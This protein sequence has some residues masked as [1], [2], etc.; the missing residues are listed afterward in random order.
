LRKYL[1]NEYSEDEL[2]ELFGY[3]RENDHGAF[4]EITADLWKSIGEEK[5]MDE[6]SARSLIENAI[7]S[8]KHVNKARYR[9]IPWYKAAAAAVL[10]LVIGGG[11]FHWAFHGK[12]QTA[13]AVKQ[14]AKEY[15]NDVKPGGVKAILKAGQSQVVLNARDTSFVLAGNVVHIKQGDVKIAESEPVQYTL[16]TPKGGEYSLVL[17][18]GTKVT[19]NADSKLVYP[20]VFHGKTRTV[21]L[22]GEGYFTVTTDP[23][24]PFI[25]HTDMQDVRVLGTEFNVQA[26]PDEKKNVTTLI[27]GKVQVSSGG[28]ELRLEDGQQAISNVQGKLTLNPNAD[29]QQAIAWKEG[30]FRFYLTDIREIMRQLSRWYDVE[31][32]Y[33]EG[34]EPR[35]FLAFINRNNNISEVLKMLE[36]TGEIHFQIE[37]R[38]VTV[39]RSAP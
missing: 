20:S 17:S 18:D 31:V 34:V 12:D 2:E 35:E 32:T 8:H 38:H 24:H 28:E 10:A 29:V 15:R 30:Y 23:N 11:L 16:I 27:N 33:E 37:G 39:M 36:E 7:N 13:V 21:Q 5:K 22:T 26:Y 9:A 3:L 4:E 19:L 14:V 1:D 6:E 25:V